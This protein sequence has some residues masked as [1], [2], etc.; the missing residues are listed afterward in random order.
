MCSCLL[1]WTSWRI[2]IWLER[3][4]LN[5]KSQHY[6]ITLIVVSFLCFAELTWRMR[7]NKAAIP[8]RKMCWQS[9][10]WVHCLSTPNLIIFEETWFLHCYC[11][12]WIIA[13]MNKQN[14]ECNCQ[15]WIFVKSLSLRFILHLFNSI[16]RKNARVKARPTQLIF[17]MAKEIMP[18]AYFCNQFRPLWPKWIVSKWPNIQSFHQS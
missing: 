15:L 12:N 7:K 1:C 11:V 10:T 13:F 5:C 4:V 8:Q 3:R 16:L 17:L 18:H 14:L 9:R 2:L 6:F